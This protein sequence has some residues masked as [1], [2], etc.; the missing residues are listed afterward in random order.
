MTTRRV[1][2]NRSASTGVEPAVGTRKVGELYVNLADRQM[3]VIDATQTPQNLL[4][5]TFFV[6]TAG[7]ALGSFVVN[8]GTL[9]VSNTLVAPGA[10]NPAQWTRIGP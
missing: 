6:S 2:T 5:V 8:A 4:A 10:F 9:Y 7:Y 3:G 1:Q